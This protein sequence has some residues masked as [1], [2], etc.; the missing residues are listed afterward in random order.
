M[1]RIWILYDKN[2][3]AKK[4]YKIYKSESELLRN[5]STQSNLTIYEYDLKSVQDP[6]EFLKSRERDTQLRSVLGELSPI[7][8]A[9]TNLIQKL[10]E[11]AE[12]NRYKKL[13]LNNLNKFIS[14]KGAISRYLTKN[15]SYFMRVSDDKDWLT[16]VLKCHNFQDP[17]FD[18]KWNYVDRKYEVVDNLSDQFKINFKLAKLEL[19][20]KN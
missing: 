6:E 11:L 14:D 10:T 5:I 4:K 20:K 15:K 1:E 18:K 2:R 19:K 16:A 13:H 8:E 17:F 3:Y 7:E 12:E 9:A